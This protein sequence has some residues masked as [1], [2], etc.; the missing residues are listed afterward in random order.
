[1]FSNP[2][3]ALFLNEK[4]WLATLAAAAL[5]AWLSYVRFQYLLGIAVLLAFV[6]VATVL[7]ACASNRTAGRTSNRTPRP[8]PLRR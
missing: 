6:A 3:G 4:R 7:A 5:I 8:R 2:N 1:M